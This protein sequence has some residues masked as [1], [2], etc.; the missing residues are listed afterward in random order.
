[1]SCGDVFNGG[2]EMY[3]VKVH[4]IDNNKEQ[5]EAVDVSMR[6]HIT[7]LKFMDGK[8][9]TIATDVIYAIERI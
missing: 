7:I 6:G 8:E 3:I 4:Y 9:K 1:V 2:D 5:F